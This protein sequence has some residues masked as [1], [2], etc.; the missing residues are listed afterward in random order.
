[1]HKLPRFDDVL[2]SFGSTAPVAGL[3]H[4]FYRYPARFSP[5]FVRATINAFTEP[6][7][8]VID[9]FMGGGTTAVEALAT[10]RRFV[11]TDLNRL[12]V[13]IARTKT[14]PLTKADCKRLLQW[15][16]LIETAVFDS[17]LDAGAA[18]ADSELTRNVPWCAL[19]TDSQLN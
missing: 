2:T 13:F 11:G 17:S 7:D 3:T 9:P 15:A 18:V 12:A 8:L 19:L 16:D 4:T 5:E 1:M 14:T 6:G 10:R